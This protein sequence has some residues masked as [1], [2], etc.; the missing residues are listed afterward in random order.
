[1]SDGFESDLPVG[2]VT[3]GAVKVTDYITDEER[4]F[5]YAALHVYGLAGLPLREGCARIRDGFSGAGDE[6]RERRAVRKIAAVTA[7]AKACEQADP[8]KRLHDLFEE[9]GFALLGQE[10]ALMGMTMAELE[11]PGV[12][13]A[14]FGALANRD[15]RLAR[16]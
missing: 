10:R 9:A 1:M 8:G 13:A 15:L 3:A 5:V 11:P 7:L 12:L 2:D 4:A 14:V 16:H 6:A